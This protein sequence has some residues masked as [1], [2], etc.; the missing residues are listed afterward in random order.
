[1]DFLISSVY[2]VMSPGPKWRIRGIEG[3]RSHFA[4]RGTTG[5][6][7]AR[8]AVPTFGKLG[9]SQAFDSRRN[10]QKVAARDPALDAR[11]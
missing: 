5:N 9:F 3:K 10:R 11:G 6:R 8:S 7:S 2:A 1:M 4:D